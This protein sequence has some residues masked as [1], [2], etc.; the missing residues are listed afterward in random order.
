[1]AEL[2]PL[3]ATRGITA[4]TEALPALLRSMSSLGPAWKASDPLP[5]SYRPLIEQAITLAQRML[6]PAGPEAMTVA[7]G[8]LLEW[9]ELFGIVALPHEPQARGAK[10]RQ[11]G[12]F[13]RDGLTE[14]PGD[15]LLIAV[16]R[17]LT[18]HK[19]STLPKVAEVREHISAD[20]AARRIELGRLQL[21]AKIGRFEPPPARPEDRPVASSV[22][23]LA[24]ALRVA[25]LYQR[26]GPAPPAEAP[27]AETRRPLGKSLSAEHL[28]LARSRAAAHPAAR[29]VA[30]PVD[31][32][33]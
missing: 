23:A 22:R 28:A 13:Y 12:K 11:I 7:I 15:L 33:E 8:K 30:E 25:P 20:W 21:A 9:V 17:T 10:L 29:H 1:M 14:V 4:A 31:E 3:P 19:Y 27:T 5:A 18:S 32:V 6:E 24:E 2:T 26:S 16:E